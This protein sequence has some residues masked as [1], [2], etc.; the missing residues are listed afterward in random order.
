MINLSVPLFNAAINTVKTCNCREN[1]EENHHSPQCKHQRICSVCKIY[2][3]DWKK[4]GCPE[5]VYIANGHTFSRWQ[6]CKTT[7]HENAHAN[8]SRQ[9]RT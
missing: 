8:E 4:H 7:E 5:R 6:S 3:F 9:K 1:W 2:F